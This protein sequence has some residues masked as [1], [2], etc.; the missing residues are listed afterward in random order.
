MADSGL[1]LCRSPMDAENLAVN[2]QDLAAVA[3]EGVLEGRAPGRLA[4]ALAQGRVQ[5]PPEPVGQLPVV[6][7]IVQ[8]VAVH[9]FRQQLTRPR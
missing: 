6:G 9:P 8:H 1:L 4:H 3:L 5:Q 7:G 2:G